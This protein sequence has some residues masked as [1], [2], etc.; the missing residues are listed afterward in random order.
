[1]NLRNLK[2][3]KEN[4]N[5]DQDQEGENEK[6]KAALT[7]NKIIVNGVD[8]TEIRQQLAERMEELKSRQLVLD[9]GGFK[10]HHVNVREME[11]YIPVIEEDEYDQ[12]DENLHRRSSIAYRP[13]HSTDDESSAYIHPKLAAKIKSFLGEGKV[14]NHGYILHDHYVPLRHTKGRSSD[15]IYPLK[16][17]P[18]TSKP[19]R[20]ARVDQHCY[21][22][23]PMWADPKALQK[24]RRARGAIK[25]NQKGLSTGTKTKLQKA[26]GKHQPI[27][28]DKLLF[29]IGHI[30][31]V[32][33]SEHLGFNEVAAMQYDINFKDWKEQHRAGDLQL[34]EGS[35]IK[36][37]LGVDLYISSEDLL[38]HHIH[39]KLYKAH[40]DGSKLLG[41]GEFEVYALLKK[42]YHKKMSFQTNTVPASSDIPSLPL[43]IECMIVPNK[44]RTGHVL[45]PPGHTHIFADGSVSG[46]FKLPAV[47][48]NSN[49]VAE[50][51]NYDGTIIGGESF[52]TDSLA[53]M[54]VSDNK[55]EKT[56]EDLRWRKKVDKTNLNVEPDVYESK[57]KFSNIFKEHGQVYDTKRQV[58]ADP[59]TGKEKKFYSL[60]T[61]VFN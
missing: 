56:K 53:E 30:E 59:L 33:T 9:T 25:A 27:S 35:K 60:K 18:S 41:E 32:N 44:K 36:G 31:V 17:F 51:E 7:T 45:M 47:L 57:V 26:F 29:K 55:S 61:K 19:F 48:G 23:D 37:N 1:M 12:L 15:V 13:R 42:G 46:N 24:E 38:Q 6:E 4:K 20:Q 39:V 52:I 49:S 16:G 40:F 34:T 3:R 54:T 28:A 43:I 10:R 5:Y 14:E 22:D 8:V 21:D 58:F 2:K 50:G 11:D